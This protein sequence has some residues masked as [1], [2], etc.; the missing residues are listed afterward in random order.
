V[1]ELL[2]DTRM[3]GQWYQH[4]K[5]CRELKRDKDGRE[6]L[7]YFIFEGFWPVADR[8]LVAL[9]RV[10]RDDGEEFACEMNA[11][12]RDSE[13]LVPLNKK[14]VRVTDSSSTFSLI[15]AERG[16]T[17]LT[18]KTFTDPSGLVP[19]FLVNRYM[20][21]VPFQA[22]QNMRAFLGGRERFCKIEGSTKAQ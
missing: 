19:S 2:L 22:L 4:L 18:Y 1:K 16:R 13:A 8:D 21:C 20:A 12:G 7:Y 5:E 6:I 17:R 3:A 10:T 15:R 11:A 14:Y 9:V